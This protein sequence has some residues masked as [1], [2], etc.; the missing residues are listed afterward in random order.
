MKKLADRSSP[1][2][3][4]ARQTR[5]Q[6]SILHSQHTSDQIETS[7]VHHDI[8]DIT[9]LRPLERVFPHHLANIKQMIERDGAIFKALIADRRSGT[10]LDGSHRY[11]YLYAEG[12]RLAPVYWVDYQDE[13]IRVGS[14]LSHRF[15]IDGDSDISKRECLRRS[16]T[17]ELFSP[18]TTRHFF[19]F[20]KSDIHANLANLNKGPERSIDH[21]LSSAHITDEIDH[22]K[23]Y[24]LEIDEELRTVSD[25]IAEM[26]ESRTYLTKQV[27]MLT[28]SLPVAFFPG[29]F[30]PPHMGHVQTI[31]GLAPHYRQLI[32]GVTGDVPQGRMMSRDEIVTAL[33]NVLKSIPNVDVVPV[34]GTL[35]QKQDTSGLPPFNLLVSGNPDVIAWARRMHLDAQFVE[36]SFGPGCSGENI[37]LGLKGSA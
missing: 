27:E 31:L 12:Y 20:R 9:T 5:R 7:I 17:G 35:V 25:Y 24:L 32:V 28:R 13:N 37:R 29:K 1:I 21:L 36:R 22:N 19:P 15:L 4:L 2:P 8:A 16:A 34:Q 18:R 26:V 23:R 11:A 33:H 6:A 14:R 3:G 10:V 30:H